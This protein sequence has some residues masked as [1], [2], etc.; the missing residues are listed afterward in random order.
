MCLRPDEIIAASLVLSRIY[1]D[2]AA[3]NFVSRSQKWAFAESPN[4]NCLMSNCSVARQR[5][6]PVPFCR[7][8][9]SS[10]RTCVSP[11]GHAANNFRTGQVKVINAYLQ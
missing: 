1:I 9:I 8:V 5:S 2:I 4:K 3:L 10:P 6:V 7:A 11:P